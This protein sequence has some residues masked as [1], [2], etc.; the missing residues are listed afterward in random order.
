MI[1]GTG[2][3]RLE[4]LFCRR[5]E[6]EQVHPKATA[7]SIRTEDLNL[8]VSLAWRETKTD[9][10]E[11][12]LTLALRPDEAK[13]QPY[14]VVVT[15]VGRFAFGALPEGLQ[16]DDFVQRNAA[17]ILFPYVREML[18]HLTAR[19]SAGPVTLP[20]INVVAMLD[21][22]PSETEEEAEDS[23]SKA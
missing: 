19:G 18:S 10:V 4:Q 20:P 14:R 21:Q 16:K 1:K 3:I 15:Y 23:F 6:Y 9:G 7:R 22:V 11:I 13:E 5:A 12:E 8:G 17:A 2:H